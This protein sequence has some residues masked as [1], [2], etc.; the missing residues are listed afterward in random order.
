MNET[1]IINI[2]I[3][4][5]DFLL[6]CDLLG[7]SSYSSGD[8]VRLSDQASLRYISTEKRMAEGVSDIIRLLLIFGS[9]V[10][11][12]TVAD[13]LWDRLQN[14]EIEK[15]VIDGEKLGLNRDDIERIIGE[16]IEQGTR[17]N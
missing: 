10:L 9:S 8:E 7:K 14:R 13:W 6:L 15:L 4:T 2:E 16:R 5:H 17:K 11:A 3:H 1:T 12:S